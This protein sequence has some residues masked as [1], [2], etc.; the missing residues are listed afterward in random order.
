[1]PRSFLFLTLFIISIPVFPIFAAEESSPTVFGGKLRSASIYR[2]NRKEALE[3]TD[4]AQEKYN[5]LKGGATQENK[6]ELLQKLSDNAKE[7]IT[8]RLDAALEH[9]R[10]F[11]QMARGSDR[12]TDAEKSVA[13][14][15]VSDF[16]T[17]AEDY[18]QEIS[19]A[20]SLDE[21]KAIFARV[22]VDVRKTMSSI[23]ATTGF[24]N[25][26]RANK[27]IDR[28]DAAA[29]KLKAHIDAAAAAGGDTAEATEIYD[30]GA[31]SLESAKKSYDAALAELKNSPEVD[32]K[33]VREYMQSAN[34]ALRS[35]HNSFST[36]TSLLRDLY[37]V[38]PW[39]VE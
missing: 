6:I 1:M 36:A 2:R 20:E 24:L 26:S 30:E 8:K 28:M 3:K 4:R 22:R 33:K 21:L 15:V 5:E 31:A 13:E 29:G 19:A 12:L 14:D 34:V 37:K 27:L 7:I 35:A 38:T 16:E 39:E 18:K 9:L 32:M 17:L 11:L 25:A 23:G 10:A